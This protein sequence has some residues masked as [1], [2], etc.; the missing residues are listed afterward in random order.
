MMAIALGDAL[1]NV[2]SVIE[3]TRIGSATLACRPE[4]YP[5]EAITSARAQHIYNWLLSMAN[6]QISDDD[7]QRAVTRFALTLAPDSEKE[8]VRR[9]LIEN[10]LATR[11][12]YSDRGALFDQRQFHH[13]VVSHSRLLFTEGHYFHAVFEAAKAYNRAVKAKA[14][15]SD[16]GVALMMSVWGCQNGVLK[17]TPCESQTDRDVQD[18]LKFLSS[19]LMQAIRNPTAHEPAIEWPIDERDCVD[20]LSFI[21]FL[22]RK[23]DAAVAW[24]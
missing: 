6:R 17:V 21:S 8:T 2:T 20:I 24:I 18:G 19:G 7:R 23:L 10:G 14:G 22:F 9:I 12:V 5:D 13:E 1:K 16:D 11:I 3:I 4:V 15:R